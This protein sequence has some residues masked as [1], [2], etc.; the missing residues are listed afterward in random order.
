LQALVPELREGVEE[1]PKTFRRL[2]PGQRKKR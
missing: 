2:K 1:P